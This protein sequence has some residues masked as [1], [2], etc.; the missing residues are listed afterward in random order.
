MEP[1]M[2]NENQN[3]TGWKSRLENTID[4]GGETCRDKNELWEKLDSR[5]HGN[6]R[7]KRF[8]W[9]WAAAACLMLAL[10]FPFIKGNRIATDTINT[11]SEKI[12]SKINHIPQT[13][14]AI[15]NENFENTIVLF[16]KKQ[17]KNKSVLPVNHQAVSS[18]VVTGEQPL[19][20]ATNVSDEVQTALAVTPVATTSATP[21]VIAITTPVI[22][23]KLK[24]V[25]NNE[26]GD[27]IEDRHSNEHIAE[28]HTIRIEFMSQEI[29][30]SV[31]PL[32][33]ENGYPIFKT[34]TSPSN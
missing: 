19:N 8:V 20:K 15:K 28:Y 10:M 4:L 16:E 5:L 2:L 13:A 30:T 33:T 9:Y 11:A 14:P 18:N 1:G 22:R 7:R 26:L 23:Q 31:A 24:V 25:H 12:Q 34:K 21:T 27:I 32:Q 6:P 3:K 17:P 29:F